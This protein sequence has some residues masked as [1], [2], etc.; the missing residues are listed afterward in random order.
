MNDPLE[1]IKKCISNRENFVLTGGA[2]SGK[3]KSLMDVIADI[4]NDDKRA[5]IAC[6]TYTNVAA[7]EIRARLANPNTNFSST[8]IHDFLWEHIKGFQRNL[9][10]ALIE[11]TSSGRIKC[12]GEIKIDNEHLKDVTISYKQHSKIEEGS[13]SH[14]EVII[15]SHFLF[16]K[17]PLLSQ[18]MADSFD[19]I[20]IDEYQDTDPLV[21]EIFLRFIQQSENH[22]VIGLFGDSMQSIYEGSIGDLTEYLQQR[23]VKEVRKE[24]N[25][26]CSQKVIDLLNKLRIDGLQQRIQKEEQ[27]K[28]VAYFIYSTSQGGI[29]IDGLKEKYISHDMS[30]APED[31]KELYLTHR[32]IAERMGFQCLFN[33]YKYKDDLIGD[34]PDKLT[35]FLLRIPT[36]CYLYQSKLIKMFIEE[37]D[38]EI[39]KGSDLKLVKDAVEEIAS[40]GDKTIDEVVNRASTLKLIQAN[41]DVALLLQESELYRSIKDL[42]Y[43]ELVNALIYRNNFSPFHTQHGVKGAEFRNVLIVL[44]NGKWSQYNFQNLFEGTGKDTIM[45]RTRKIFYVC[46]SRAK[47]N[48]FVYFHQPTQRVIDQAK[49]WFG[50][51]NVIDVT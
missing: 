39:I 9:K 40:S 30:R 31:Y 37:I 5:K 17:Y 22:P 1:D 12:S 26:R 44:D 8:T 48:L 29:S 15:I 13:I 34:T 24:D 35:S 41:V 4:L 43:Q 49:V 10:E 25:W 33:Q 11:L 7:N 20:F 32:L 47:E 38:F 45:N 50:E 27:L 23:I 51:E 28:G 14:D 6:I 18:I 19:F 3:T 16:E 46:C 2:G 36:V 21:I 42:K